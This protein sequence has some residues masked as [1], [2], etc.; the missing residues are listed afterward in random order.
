M[1]DYA[2]VSEDKLRAFFGEKLIEGV[3]EEN[4]NDCLAVVNAQRLVECWADIR[5]IIADIP[6]PEWLYG[7][8]EQLDAR[9]ELAHIGLEDNQLDALLEYSPLVRN[10]L[11][12]MRARRMI[13]Y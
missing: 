12:L 5:R 11:T 9:R 10:R 4:R 8:L 6:S 2:P 1:C 3:V 13:K 7:L